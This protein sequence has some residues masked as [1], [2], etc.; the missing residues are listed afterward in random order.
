MYIL[1]EPNVSMDAITEK[2]ISDLYENILENKIGIIIAH[3][4]INIVD[5]IIVL[6][7]GEIVEF[8]KHK[9]VIK[10][11]KIYKQLAKL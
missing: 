5:K 10:K 9:E 7:N 2:E 4:F 3:R 8:G 1:D 6:Q 11:G